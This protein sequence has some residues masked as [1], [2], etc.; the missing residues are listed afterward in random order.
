MDWLKNFLIAPKSLIEKPAKFQHE[1]MDLY[2][3]VF[4]EGS[5]NAQK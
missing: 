5:L 3:P 2:V 1:K 4:F